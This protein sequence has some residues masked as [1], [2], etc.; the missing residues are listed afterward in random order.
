MSAPTYTQRIK[1]K[2][3]TTILGP[4]LTR[5]AA[6]GRAPLVGKLIRSLFVTLKQPQVHESQAITTLILPKPGF[7]EDIQASLGRDGRFRIVSLDRAYTKF[8]YRAFLPK[9]VDD[10]NYRSAPTE[11]ADKKLQLRD[12]WQAA[13]P[14]VS[15]GQIDVLLTGNFSYHAEQELTAALEAHGTPVVALH[16]ECLKSPALE[17]FYEHVYRERKIPFQ[18]RFISTYNEIERDIQVRAGTVSPDRVV[19]SGMARLDKIHHWREKFGGAIRRTGERPT[20]LFMSFNAR[21][22]APLISR[23]LPGRREILDEAQEAVGWDRLVVECHA[24][25][26]DLARQEPDI[27]VVIKAKNH[28]RALAVIEESFGHDFKTPANLKIICGGDPFSLIT[29][30]DVLCGFNSTS[31]FEALAANVPIVSP[32][33]VEAAAEDTKGYVIDLGDAAERAHS[34]QELI[35]RLAA[36]ARS[37]HASGHA[38]TLADAQLRAL[39]HWLGNPDG[40]AGERVASLVSAIVRSEQRAAA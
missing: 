2:V 15:R 22:G 5:L 39:D 37:A 27:D 26:V 24:A 28:A 32:H 36:R 8:V 3:G 12:F 33:F 19:V 40:K 16:K 6:E 17:T 30:A 14:H 4:I 25:M 29:Q 21:T 23:K 31:L 1:R 10:N 13:W 9:T 38:T 18:G 35:A 34:R 20:A 7:S 11:T